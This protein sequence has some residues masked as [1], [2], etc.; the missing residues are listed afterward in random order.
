[1]ILKQEEECS[2]C[3]SIRHAHARWMNFAKGF[4]LYGEG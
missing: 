1:M 4:V 3:T 2:E